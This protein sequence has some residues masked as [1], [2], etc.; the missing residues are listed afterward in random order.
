MSYPVLYHATE[1]D[2]NHLGLGVLRDAMTCMVVEERNGRFQLEMTYPIDGAIADELQ[3]DRIIKA[4]AGHSLKGQLFRI[5]VI[6]K[7]EDGLI[8]VSANHVSYLAQSLVLNP[9]VRVIDQTAHQALETWQRNIIGDHPFRVNSDIVS[10]HSTMLHIRNHQ[11]ARQA[12]GGAEGSILDVWGGEYRF[13]N[14]L[15][16]LLR[17]RGGRAN[18]LIS[19]GRNLTHLEQEENIGNTVTSIYPYAVFRGEN[20]VEQIVTLQGTNMVLDSENAAYFAHR[21]VLPVDFSR[22]FDREDTPAF[23]RSRLR[24]L[25]EAFMEEHRIGI[26]KVSIS[27]R[28]VDLT[29]TLNQSG[30]VYEQLNLCDEVPVRFEKLGIDTT[31]K[32]ARITWDVLLD[33]YESLDIGEIRSS[34]SE[35]IRVVEREVK[36]AGESANS[37]LTAANGKNTVFFGIDEPTATRVGDIWYRP[38]EEHTEMLMWDGN[39]WKFIVSTAPDARLLN[40]IEEARQRAEESLDQASQAVNRANAAF[41]KVE[42]LFDMT[43]PV[44]GE[45]TTITA[46]AKGWQSAV[47]DEHGHSRITQLSDIINLRT[48]GESIVNQINIS[49]GGI[50]LDANRIQITGDTFIEQAAITNALIRDLNANRIET[51]ELVAG[52][53]DV[54]E[55]NANRITSG[56]LSANFIGA[57]TISTSHLDINHY[58]FDGESIGTVGNADIV[59]RRG[60]TGPVIDRPD[61]HGDQRDRLIIG[62][63][64]IRFYLQPDNTWLDNDASSTDSEDVEG[65]ESIAN[66]PLP[67]GTNRAGFFEMAGNRLISNNMVPRGAESNYGQP[68]RNIHLQPADRW[69]TGIPGGS[70]SPSRYRGGGEVRCT[71][72][73][74]FTGTG[75]SQIFAPLRARRLSIQG[76]TIS[77]DESAITQN[78]SRHLGVFPDSILS[79]STTVNRVRITG[80]IA[81]QALRGLEARDILIGSNVVD[82]GG[83][84]TVSR[85]GTTT[86]GSETNNNFSIR[87]NGL[88]R[89][90]LEENRALIRGRETTSN[91]SM[92]SVTL[93]HRGGSA[94]ANTAFTFNVGQSGTNVAAARRARVWSMGIYRRTGTA[95]SNM[96]RV[97]TAGTLERTSSSER[98]KLNINRGLDLDFAERI[99]KV[100]PASWFDRN[101]AETYASIMTNSMDESG[102]VDWEQVDEVAREEVEPIIRIGGVIAEDVE[103][104]GLGMYVSYGLDGKTV[105]GVQYD[106]L[107]TLL[108]PIVKEQKAKIEK[109]EARIQDL[110]TKLSKEVTNIKKQ[111]EELLRN[112]K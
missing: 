16:Q 58:R 10:R 101:C 74:N 107:W 23:M 44:T 21:R 76:Q 59:L 77:E 111:M 6:D 70:P 69:I 109:Q 14:Y 106:R 27:L 24:D 25:G 29:K 104:A 78:V 18:T 97:T 57:G 3:V 55:L 99:L 89:I 34:L 26:P 8:S 96:L 9:E 38:N 71:Y 39:G 102:N 53:A 79:S 2:F 48:A 1:T 85:L 30:L 75:G 103:K 66:Q 46:L 42:P 105:E 84:R 91:A 64:K 100:K 32:I 31:A 17:N 65:N 93:S 13:D 11:N 40:R 68:L 98:Y 67:S 15:V 95:S 4:D 33:E 20:D 81:G 50:M 83:A 60:M 61:H 112:G 52:I 51:R 87:R 49:P 41:D 92:T 90:V 63:S 28:F 43:D 82:S 86:V 7:K 80:D 54:I 94:T 45:S 110:E 35:R 5:E 62:Q 36:D 108:I 88:S 73:T 56:K 72:R 12:L 22:E 37:A 19:Y 47:L